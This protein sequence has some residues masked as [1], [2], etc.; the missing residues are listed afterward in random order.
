MSNRWFSYAIIFLKGKTTQGSFHMVDPRRFKRRH[1]AEYVIF[2]CK[3]EYIRALFSG[4]TI[5]IL[6]VYMMRLTFIFLFLNLSWGHVS[7]MLIISMTYDLH[8]DSSCVIK[9]TNIVK[10]LS[11]AERNT[12]YHL[13]NFFRYF[14]KQLIRSI[15]QITNFLQ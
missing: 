1:H 12:S 3:N 10:I 15:N 13:I 4:F 7:T 6:M 2:L 11:V 5:Y 14:F 8:C 9:V